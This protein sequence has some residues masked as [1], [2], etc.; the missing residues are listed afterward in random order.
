M[1]GGGHGHG[2]EDTH[3]QATY[4]PS[5]PVKGAR[6]VKVVDNH[7]MDFAERAYVMEVT[8]GLGVTFRHFFTTLGKLVRGEKIETVEYPEQ[9]VVYSG[10]FRGLHRLVPRDDGTPRCVAC[11]M[12]ATACPAHCIHII[13]EPRKDSTTEKQPL[14]FEIDELRCVDCGLCVEACPCDAIRM[15]SNVHPPPSATREDQLMG[16]WDLL[17]VMGIVDDGKTPRSAR[18][19]EGHQPGKDAGGH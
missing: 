16:R 14:Q 6:D 8:K 2:H 9:K 13:A 7:L 15:D 11:F 17:G 1:A 10:R 4:V 18:T 3:T 5:M 19:M 12:C